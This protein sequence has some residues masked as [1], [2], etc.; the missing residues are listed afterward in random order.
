MAAITCA[1]AAKSNAV[2]LTR[3]C[4]SLANAALLLASSAA[5]VFAF[6]ERGAFAFGIVRE[7]K[8]LASNRAS[9]GKK[10]KPSGATKFNF[11]Q[12]F[13]KFSFVCDR[14]HRGHAL[15]NPRRRRQPHRLR[16]Q[17]QRRSAC[18]CWPMPT[19]ALFDQAMPHG[20]SEHEGR[21]TACVELQLRVMHERWTCL[22]LLAKPLAK[23]SLLC[24]Y[25]ARQR[26]RKIRAT[27]SLA[28]PVQREFSPWRCHSSRTL[29]LQNSRTAK[30]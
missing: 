20:A 24:G 2:C 13:H 11:R 21:W 1:T 12:W 16:P 18:T 7:R 4:A 23:V 22:C 29:A 5:R 3:M 17:R 14:D 8:Q 6:N 15:E 9:N 25:T 30:A 10:P 26:P 27:W 19:K 28:C